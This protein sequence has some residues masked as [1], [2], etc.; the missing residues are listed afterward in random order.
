MLTA[1]SVAVVWLSLLAAG[2]PLVCW[3]TDPRDGEDAALLAPFLGLAALVLPLNGLVYLDVPVRAVT[4]FL[5][6]ALAGAA[7]LAV[8]RGGLWRRFRGWPGVVLLAAGAVYLVQGL[9]L[10]RV[11]ARLY[12]GLGWWDEYHYDALAQF[13]RDWPFR[14]SLAEVGPH[15]LFLAWPIS[16][17]CDRIGQS[18]LQAFFA[19]SCAAPSKPLFGPTILLLPALTVP[20]V[21]LAARRAGLARGPALVTGLAAGLLPAVTDVHLDCFLSQALGVPLLLVFPVVL[22]DLLARPGWRTLARAALLLA[23]AAAV[24]TELL[25]ILW[26]LILLAALVHLTRRPFPGR[27]A[28]CLAI[29]PLVALV[30]NA[31]YVRYLLPVA[32]RVSAPAVSVDTLPWA[33]SLEAWARLWLGDWASAES[34][35]AV[36]LAGLGL[37]VLAYLGLGLGVWAALGAVRAGWQ[38]ADARRAV[39]RAAA[40]AAVAALPL[41]VLVKDD[42]HPYQFCKL[43]LTVGPLLV[44]GVALAG[45]E[46]AARLAAW[47]PVRAGLPWLG[48]SA[49][50]ALGAAA[51]VPMVLATT[52]PDPRPRSNAY[53][54]HSADLARLQDCLGGAAGDDL[55]LAQHDGYLNSWLGYF[56]RKSRV[57]LLEP[58]YFRP[59]QLAEL[60]PRVTWDPAGSPDLPVV[61][62]RKQ[63]AFARVEPGEMDLEWEGAWFQL[64]RARSPHWALPVVLT[65]ANGLESL[66]GAPFFWV[67]G[68][69]TAL[70]LVAG[71]P[72]RVTLRGTFTPGPGIPGVADRSLRL[73]TSAG[74]TREL[75][76]TGGA[77]ALTL[78]VPAGRSTISLQSLDEALGPTPNGDSRPLLLGVR[79]L[80]LAFS[81][82]EESYP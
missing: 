9:G 45:H 22:D 21:C 82:A 10:L 20:A 59:D 25:L 39:F 51:T 33:Y 48:P 78:P 49:L 75:H 12:V 73:S 7:A 68:K 76:T 61:L 79:G 50:L 55:L 34:G 4:P 54:L 38:D 66:D 77:F 74:Y 6:V 24:Y 44:L 64:W 26:A 23:A 72:G 70:E 69:P 40:L 31:G 56:A 53:L 57:H 60:G 63:G 15:N 5:W 16:L 71:A 37:T 19:A 35:A 65:N 41:L 47:R 18:V 32:L 30:F 11:G 1:L 42:R 52:R 81:P 17:K 46:A 80:D 8:Q 58:D 36:R 3:L 67:G 14:T 62:T 2:V 29:L 43:L 27:A 13:F 28:A